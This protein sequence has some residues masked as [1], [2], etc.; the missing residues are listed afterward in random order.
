LTRGP[1]QARSSFFASAV[2]IERREAQLRAQ[3]A[4]T[5]P[6]TLGDGFV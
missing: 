6:G 1:G 3:R 5:R 4:A 2:C